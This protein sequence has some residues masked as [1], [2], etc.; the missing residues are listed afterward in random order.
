MQ[1]TPK[2]TADDVIRV[3]QRDFPTDTEAVMSSLQVYGTERWHREVDRVRLAI[4]KLA[5]GDATKVVAHMQLA[6]TDYRDVLAG[7][8][9]PDYTRASAHDLSDDSELACE[10]VN[11]DWEQ[12][13]TWLNRA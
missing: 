2:V 5:A 7:A 11:R 6:C 13:Q 3:V 1:P 12:Y 4:L 10:L 8:E 9:Y